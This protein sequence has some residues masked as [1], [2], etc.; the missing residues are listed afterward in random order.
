MASCKVGSESGPGIH[1][2]DFGSEVTLQSCNVAQCEGPCVTA[3]QS[4]SIRLN[5]CLLQV[6]N[7]YAS[8]IVDICDTVCFDL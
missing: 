1:A 5:A 4:A 3:S 7:T 6:G 2:R 8:S